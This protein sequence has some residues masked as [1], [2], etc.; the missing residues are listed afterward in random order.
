MMISLKT[1]LITIFTLTAFEIANTI[2]PYSAVEGQSA[3]DDARIQG[4]VNFNNLIQLFELWGCLYTC[5]YKELK[6]L[7]LFSCRYSRIARNA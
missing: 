4:N 7:R 5:I 6:A 1:Q 2:L 3:L